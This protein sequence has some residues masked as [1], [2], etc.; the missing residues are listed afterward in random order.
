M[1]IQ[2]T[3]SIYKGFEMRL[4]IKY[5]GV[6]VAVIAIVVAGAAGYL[7]GL[8]E[9]RKQ[10]I[11]HTPEDWVNVSAWEGVAQEES[12][13]FTPEKYMNKSFDLN[14]YENIKFSDDKLEETRSDDDEPCI[15]YP[16]QLFRFKVTSENIKNISVRWEGL[17]HLFDLVTNGVTVYV[18]NK[19]LYNWTEIGNYTNQ[20]GTQTITAFLGNASELIDNENFIFILA[21]CKILG[22]GRSNCAIKTDYVEVKIVS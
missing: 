11:L 4:K 17:G 16:Y 6:I 22:E 13:V 3:C 18:W 20:T 10:H 8:Q 5:L 7:L 1:A 19:M 12:P 21:Y 15:G 14:G 9:G 2:P